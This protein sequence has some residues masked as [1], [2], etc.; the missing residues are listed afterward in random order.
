MESTLANFGAQRYKASVYKL[1]VFT[2]QKEPEVN[3]KEFVL[4][5]RAESVT[6]DVC[7]SCSRNHSGSR[8]PILS[9][10]NLPGSV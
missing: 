5:L 7:K 2:Q 3:K 10:K 9:A 4:F 8:H 6:T 1:L